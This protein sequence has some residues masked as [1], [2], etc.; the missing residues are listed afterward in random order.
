MIRTNHNLTEKT[1]FITF[2]CI[3][4]IP[5]FE[6]TDSYNLVY[7]WLK[8]IDEKYHVKTLAFVIMPNHA[9]FILQ[10]PD[11]V[12]S[13]NTIVA[14]GKRFMAYDLVKALTNLERHDLLTQLSDV[15]TD[16]EKARGQKHK[17]FEPS[18][19]AKPIYTLAFLNQK[20][21]YIHHNPVSGK[22]SLCNEYTDYPHSSA[23]F[24]ILGTHHQ[25]VSITNYQVFWE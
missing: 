9:H 13:L 20:L 14:N 21:D 2:T 7:N 18:F 12:K 6:I 17:L 23:A 19:D 22:W 4:W 10:L 3:N 11:S 24:Y 16:K 25:F 8:I 15:C 1:W 5:L